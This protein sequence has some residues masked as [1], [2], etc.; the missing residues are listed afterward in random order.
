MINFLNVHF[1]QIKPFLKYIICALLSKYKN[2]IN[3]FFKF[4]K[5][6]SIFL[7]SRQT[8]LFKVRIESDMP[9]YKGESEIS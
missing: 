5:Y 3:F 1:Q 6:N 8:K 2:L 7:L 4:W 9:L